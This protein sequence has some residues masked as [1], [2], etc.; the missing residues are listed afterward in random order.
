[1][2]THRISGSDERTNHL[3]AAVRKLAML[4]AIAELQRLRVDAEGNMKKHGVNG[5]DKPRW[6]GFI[7]GISASIYRLEMH[8]G[9]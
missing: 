1:M 8:A 3:R 9:E 4:D 6:E 2:R 5:R 7:E